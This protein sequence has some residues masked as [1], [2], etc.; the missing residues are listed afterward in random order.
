MS[1][2]ILVLV[3]LSC[4]M[5]NGCQVSHGH[6]LLDPDQD[7]QQLANQAISNRQFSLLRI[8]TSPDILPG[9]DT[10]LMPLVIIERQCG[11]LDVTVPSATPD[12]DSSSA[13]L[14]KIAQYNR[15][16]FQACRAFQKDY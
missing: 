2:F 8:A 9:V 7:G 5:L 14:Q 12:T 3:L 11:V 10:K 1:R 15:Q 13:I 4:A 16:V 6:P